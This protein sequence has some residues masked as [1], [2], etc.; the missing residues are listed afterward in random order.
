MPEIELPTCPIC[1]AS[2]SLFRQVRQM[3]GKEYI[4]Y[5]CRQCGSVLLWMGKGRWAYQKIGRPDKSHLLKQPLSPDELLALVPQK[6]QAVAAKES[7]APITSLPL[8]GGQG[9]MASAAPAEKPPSAAPDTKST[10]GKRRPSWWLLGA[11]GLIAV[12]FLCAI[13]GLLTMSSPTYKAKRTEEAKAKE[14]EVAILTDTPTPTNTSKPP[15]TAR[16]AGTIAVTDTPEPTDIT[17][18]TDMAIPTDTPAPTEMLEPT[19]IAIPTDTPAPTDMPLPTNTPGPTE[20]PTPVPVPPYEIVYLDDM[21][22]ADR[23]RFTGGVAVEFPIG[24][25]QVQA[26]CTQIVEQQKARQPLNAVAIFVYDTRS[27]W[28]R[29]YSIARCVYA[30]YGDWGEAAS[31]Q[32]GDYST[33]SYDYEYRPKVYDGEIALPD[34]PTE[35]EAG[36]CLRFDEI[37]YESPLMLEEEEVIQQVAEEYG[38]SEEV[39]RDTLFKCLDWRF[40]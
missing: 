1:H 33:H 16:T 7:E 21:S 13:V 35:Q 38:I 19:D 28:Y 23:V 12:C 4:W 20:T 29:G 11:L 2:G 31:V 3:Q 8:V 30:P 34:R 32:P 40:R 6:G 39:V 26:I 10:P 18:P 15:D 24:V 17:E 27:S 9:A 22:L 5:E 14:T 25:E 37:V 36:I